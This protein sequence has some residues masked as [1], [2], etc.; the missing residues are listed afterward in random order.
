[1][2]NPDSWDKIDI[3]F[4]RIFQHPPERGL[5]L[6]VV[7]IDRHVD[8]RI[9]TELSGLKKRAE[10][11]DSLNGGEPRSRPANRVPSTIQYLQTESL[12]LLPYLAVAAGVVLAEGAEGGFVHRL[13]CIAPKLGRAVQSIHGVNDNHSWRE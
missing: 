11:V 1:M 13:Q 2:D 7:A 9:R 6:D 12:P 8:I 3:P 5:H 10:E 4:E